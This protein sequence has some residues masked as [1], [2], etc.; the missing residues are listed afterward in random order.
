MPVVVEEER[1]ELKEEV[2][3][4]IQGRVTILAGQIWKSLDANAQSSISRTNIFKDKT[5]H[6]FEKNG[7]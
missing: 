3:P 7:V 4:K 6:I 5:L 1:Y 2:I